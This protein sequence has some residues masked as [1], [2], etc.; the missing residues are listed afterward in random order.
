MS[1][2]TTSKVVDEVIRHLAGASA[3]T[4]SLALPGMAVALD[5]PLKKLFGTLDEREKARELRRIV[6]KMKETGLLVGDYEH[7]LQLTDKA[8]KRLER[9]NIQ[10]LRAPHVG[11][12][13][14]RWRIIMYDL[15]AEHSKGRHELVACLRCYGCFQL[16]KSAWITPF[17]CRPDIEAISSYYGVDRFV[18]Y[19]EAVNLDNEKALLGRF[20]R[21][22]PDTVFP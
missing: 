16:Q 13:D 11:R 8:R 18:T 22:Y 14:G 6:Y 21:K 9:I 10:D 19:F 12:W 15:P 5:G 3:L 17:P 7:G 2:E 4:V 20:R 1:R